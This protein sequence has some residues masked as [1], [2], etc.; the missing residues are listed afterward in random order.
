MILDRIE[1]LSRYAA[2]NS[3]FLLVEEFLKCNHLD[4]LKPGRHEIVGDEVFVNIV[5]LQAKSRE[6]ACLETHNEMIDVQVVIAGEEEHGYTSRSQLPEVGYDVQNDISFY[7]GTAKQ[8][9]TLS[10]NDFVIYF[11]ED[12]HAPAISKGDV[13]KAIFKVKR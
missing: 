4:T 3:R 12:G 1:N 13:R 10:P 9:F 11:P 2:L 6:E 8:Y 7:P 5:D